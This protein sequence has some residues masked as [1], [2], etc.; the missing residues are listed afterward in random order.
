MSV[1]D[2]YLKKN[3]ICWIVVEPSTRN[4]ISLRPNIVYGESTVADIDTFATLNDS[5]RSTGTFVLDGT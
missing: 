3:T 5:A 2:V 4:V 1:P